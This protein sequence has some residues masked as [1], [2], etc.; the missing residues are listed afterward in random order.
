[1]SSAYLDTHVAVWLHDGLVEKFSSRA[2][3]GIESNEL[4]VSPIV[5]LEL[6]YLKARRRITE[7]PVKMLAYLNAAFGIIVCQ[8]PFALVVHTAAS[9]HWTNDPFDRLIVGQASAADS[10][11]ITADETIR[12]HYAHSIW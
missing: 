5:Q 4:R 3:D 9:L 7:E 8:L 10:G 12:K 2:R 6:E 11:L 1:M